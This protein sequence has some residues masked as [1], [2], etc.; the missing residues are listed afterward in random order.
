MCTTGW[1]EK[2]IKSDS[3]NCTLLDHHTNPKIL[4]VHETTNSATANPII[5]WEV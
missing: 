4:W 2:K 1:L 5:T 3:F